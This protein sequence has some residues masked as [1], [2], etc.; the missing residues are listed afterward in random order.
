MDGQ[1]ALI[2]PGVLSSTTPASRERSL[3]PLF[4][5]RNRNR[6]T[7]NRRV[8]FR[9]HKEVGAVPPPPCLFTSYTLCYLLKS[10]SI[11]Q[12]KVPIECSKESRL[13]LGVDVTIDHTVPIDGCCQMI[14][15]VGK[16]N[17][18]VAAPMSKGTGRS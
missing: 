8:G 16:G 4:L 13:T 6:A 2:M 15:W 18:P 17:A 14:G 7:D 12:I 5:I 11:S 3:S 1:W 9:L 10:S